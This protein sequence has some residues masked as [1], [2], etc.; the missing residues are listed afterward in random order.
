MLSVTYKPFML[1]V[2]YKPYMLSLI[3][4]NVSMLFIIM[5]NVAM[6]FVSITT[7]SIMMLS[8]MAFSITTHHSAQWQSI[9]KLHVI[10]SVKMNCNFSKLIQ[11]KYFSWMSMVPITFKF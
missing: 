9:V 5:L 1:S 10:H 4:Q 3:V 6:L 2:T 7:F 11:S 8:I